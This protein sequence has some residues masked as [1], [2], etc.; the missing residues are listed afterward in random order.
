MSV[1]VYRVGALQWLILGALVQA[2]GQSMTVQEL[3]HHL[4]SEGV[5]FHPNRDLVAMVKNGTVEMAEFAS[6]V[7]LTEYGAEARRAVRRT[8]IP[9][10]LR[11]DDR[12]VRFTV[13]EVVEDVTRGMV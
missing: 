5:D 1:K 7:H 9:R 11:V 10:F 4:K 13:P 8:A 2:H 3:S 12:L 6:L